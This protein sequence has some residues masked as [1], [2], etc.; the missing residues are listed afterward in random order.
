M[1]RAPRLV[2]ALGLAL[3][4]SAALGQPVSRVPVGAP[5]APRAPITGWG[6]PRVDPRI[7]MLFAHRARTGE[8]IGVFYPSTRFERLGTLPVVVRFARAP[9]RAT[10]DLLQRDG[11]RWFRA[12]RPLASGAYGALV[13]ERSLAALERSALVARV[14]VD[15][16][17]NAPEP[18]ERSLTETRIDAARRALFARDGVAL[19]GRGTVIADIDSP[20]FLFHPMLF[21]ADAGAFA[22]ID[23]DRDGA[24]TPGTDAIDL[25]RDGAAGEGE[26]MSLLAGRAYDRSG[27]AL[28]AAPS[29][30]RPAQDWLYL[31]ANGNRQRDYGATFDESTPAYGEPIFVADDADGDGRLDPTER[32]LRLGTSKFR[33]TLSDVEL[34]RGDPEAGL[35]RY[36]ID[37]TPAR[38]AALGHATG[39]A[40]ILV[41]GIAGVSRWLGLAPGAELLAADTRRAGDMTGTTGSIQWALD[42]GADVILTEYAP[43]ASVTLD[44]SSEEELLLDAALAE[45]VVPVS[46]AGNLATGFKHRTVSLAAGENTVDLR[47]DPHSPVGRLLQLSVH[48]RAPARAVTYALTLPSGRRV[49]LPTSP[50]GTPLGDGH[51][52][53]TTAR[54]TARGTVERFFVIALSASATTGAYQLH[55]TVDAGPAVAADLYAGD[56]RNSW[57]GGF[58]FTENS[59]ARTLCH[60]A[61]SDDTLAVA[62]YTL[63]N[64]RAHGGSSGEGERATYSSQGPRFDG[65]DGLDIA[66]PD[67]PMSSTVPTEAGVPY[68]ALSPFGGTSGAGPHVA[69]AASLLRQLFPDESAAALRARIVT[70]ARRDRFATANTA[71]LYG[72][73]KLD[74][75]AAAELSLSAG[76]APVVR[77]EAPAQSMVGGAA[78]VRVVATDDEAPGALRARWDTDYD[79][80]PDTDWVGLDALSLATPALGS[81][82][83]RVEVRDGQGNVRGDTARIEVVAMLPPPPPPD[84]GPVTATA[85]TDEGCG[86]TAPGRSPRHLPASLMVALL[87]TCVR[88]RR[89]AK[90][91]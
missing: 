12:A 39:V 63:Y 26:V 1:R 10:L 47:V 30:L 16:P 28:G 61:T 49:D 53:Y 71:A 82:S 56:D 73:G 77:L 24:P 43:Y 6:S 59:P 34:V 88:R 50:R 67:N 69:A 68:G 40:G 5:A 36:D 65:D 46:P 76:A 4:S 48:H 90:G 57:A 20:V 70:S 78:T 25:D 60:P 11:V 23:V 79:G 75:A 14:E 51:T 21:A 42:Q 35:V 45:N 22:W 87:A 33:R 7:E 38:V 81:V 85:T 54:T 86:C 32:V 91:V 19:D 31:D 66:A 74:V 15:L 80:A 41:G 58:V 55:A 84:A 2:L 3:L 8:T 9:D 64:D 27:G 29:A 37:S 44:G 83:V 18:L 72:A 89:A 52:V 62:A 17:L 13:D